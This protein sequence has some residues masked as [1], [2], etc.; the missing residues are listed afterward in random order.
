[1]SSSGSRLPVHEFMVGGSSQTTNGIDTGMHHGRGTR[2]AVG[3]VDGLA[4]QASGRRQGSSRDEAFDGLSFRTAEAGQRTT[5][6]QP[7]EGG[8]KPEIVVSAD[9][10]HID[11]RGI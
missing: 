1:M 5:D 11:A 7:N 9:R 3:S 10:R 2:D 6:A 4:H 8:E